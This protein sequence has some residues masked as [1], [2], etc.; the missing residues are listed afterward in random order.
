MCVCVYVCVGVCVC[1]VENGAQDLT[2]GKYTLYHEHSFFICSTKLLF[3]KQYSS[4]RPC[5]T[6]HK[7]KLSGLVAPRREKFVISKGLLYLIKLN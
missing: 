7:V 2:H 5:K 3:L 1:S 6:Q 4:K